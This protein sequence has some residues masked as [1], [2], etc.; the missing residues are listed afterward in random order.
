MKT[1]DKKAF[2][3]IELLVVISIIALLLSILLPSLSKAKE[4]AIKTACKSNLKQIGTGVYMYS[5][6]CRKIPEGRPEL[7]TGG[8]ERHLFRAYGNFSGPVGLG[9]LYPKYIQDPVVFWCPAN[10]NKYDGYSVPQMVANLRNGTSAEGSPSSYFYRKKA[11]PSNPASPYVDKLLNSSRFAMV[12][13]A[14]YSD[15][16]P[17][18]HKNGYNVAFFDSHVEWVVDKG[19]KRYKQLNSPLIYGGLS[20]SIDKFFTNA[21][22]I[23]YR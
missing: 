1:A 12:T 2:T 23:D 5:S 9:T 4:S 13:D 21:D 8:F 7:E 11:K 22:H 16:T 3:L 15:S 18:N 17:P 19:N 6:E 10:R 20:W 14:A